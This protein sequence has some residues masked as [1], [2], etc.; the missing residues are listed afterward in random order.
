MHS[1]LRIV[2]GT[3]RGRKLSY[4]PN[5]RLRPAPQMVRAAL[6]SILGQGVPGKP[7]IDLFAGTGAVG[8]EALSRG[9]RP[10]TFVEKDFRVALELEKN[11]A[12]FGVAESTEV[13]KGDVYHWVERW[14]GSP[15][16]VNVFLGTPFA[17]LRQRWE[18]LQA[19]IEALIG[20]LAPG[21][22]LVVQM[23]HPAPIDKLPGGCAWEVRRYGRNL[24][25]F[26]ER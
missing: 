3:L 5:K 15:E 12:E 1:Q 2:A 10:V 19:A 16:P 22:V 24:L 4:T 25:V 9:A 6:F 23:E 18:D 7:F 14:A 13:V 26:G 21:S 8:V 17:D 20:K 11:L